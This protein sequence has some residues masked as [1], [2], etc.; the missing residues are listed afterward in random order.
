MSRY[1][2]GY[3]EAGIGGKLETGRK[4]SEKAKAL[5]P[6]SG[7]PGSP[8]A[9]HPATHRRS[10]QKRCAPPRGWLSEPGTRQAV[11]SRRPEEDAGPTAHKPPP[12]DRKSTRLNSS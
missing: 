4:T 3:Q 6:G 10:T 9:P 12:S 7:F 1:H 11:R 5:L 8:F 2:K